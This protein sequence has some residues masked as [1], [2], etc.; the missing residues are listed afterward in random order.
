[1]PT[2][3]CKNRAGNRMLLERMCLASHQQSVAIIAFSSLIGMFLPPM[4]YHELARVKLLLASTDQ[5][6]AIVVTVFEMV[7]EA[8]LGSRLLLAVIAQVCLFTDV[9]AHMVLQ[10][11]HLRER[12]ITVLAAV[13]AP[14]VRFFPETGIVDHGL[15]LRRERHPAPLVAS[16]SSQIHSL[17][18]DPLQLIQIG[19][20][21]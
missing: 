14:L 10:D 13:L 21:G 4:L 7:I 2:I 17:P 15:R 11:C 18:V 6:L 9:V 3:S 12:P 5:A 1:M 19:S 20:G 16:P 8:G